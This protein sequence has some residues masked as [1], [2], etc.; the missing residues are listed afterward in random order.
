[1]Q[2]NE[3]A[4]WAK[5]VAHFQADAH[6]IFSKLESS[7]SRNVTLDQSYKALAGLTL[8]QDEI[9]RQSLR[10]VESDLF[11]AAHV[12]AWAGFVDCL[13]YLTASDQFAQLNT[14][15]PK[16]AINSSDSLAEKFTEHALIE[17]LNVMG[18]INKAESKAFFGMLSKRNECAHPG[19]YFP[20]F[21]ET[22]GYIS[23]IFSRL[24]KIL[25]RNP[26]LKLTGGPA[27]DNI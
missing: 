12:M 4:D 14:A 8:R 23:E 20:S 5:R 10:C 27:M 24:N 18:V 21:N 16:W 11:R 17:A 3:I 15:R 9:F 19:D 22:L 6:A 26:E 7:K 2:H 1:M 13:Q 25:R